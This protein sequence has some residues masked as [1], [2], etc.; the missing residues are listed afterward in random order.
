MLSCV[1]REASGMM[2]NHTV[3]ISVALKF[4]QPNMDL[5]GM[6]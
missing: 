4:T 1:I 5:T 6:S 3:E 2:M